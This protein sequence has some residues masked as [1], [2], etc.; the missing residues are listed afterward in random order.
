M[1][2]GE[3]PHTFGQTL[4]S[5]ALKHR[6]LFALGSIATFL[7]V[8]FVLIAGSVSEG[9]LKTFDEGIML[10]LRTAQDVSDPIG[11]KWFEEGVRDVTALG[12]TTVLTLLVIA[13]TIY[14]YLTQRGR[15]A[16][17]VL[18]CTI[19]GTLL[20]SLVKLAFDRPRP[21]LVPHQVEVYTASFPSGHSLMSAVVYL[22]LGAL[23]ARTQREFSVRAAIMGM[24][25]FVTVLVGLSRVY[26]GVHW[27]SDVLAGWCLGALWATL[28][29]M[30]ARSF[31]KTLEPG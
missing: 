24:A 28:C 13:V 16:L 7:L 3:I 26:L 1:P 10:S 2:H 18:A 22:T 23:I 9:E 19:S 25:I 29:W 14:L 4:Q 17:I 27:P 20:S 8:G 6:W 31:A 5:F 15:T 21:N 11:P 12:S 30:F